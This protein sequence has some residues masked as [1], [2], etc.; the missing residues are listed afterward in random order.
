MVQGH[1]GVT[2][3]CVGS[4]PIQENELLFTDILISSLWHQG[5]IEFRHSSRNASK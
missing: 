1:K 4:F 3:T 5:K 2:V